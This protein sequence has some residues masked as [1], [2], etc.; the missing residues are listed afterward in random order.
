MLRPCVLLLVGLSFASSAQAQ[1]GLSY[2]GDTNWD[3]STG[4]IPT[5]YVGPHIFS[6]VEPHHTIARQEIFGPVLAVM[7][8]KSFGMNVLQQFG[9][10]RRKIV[11][12]ATQG[13]LF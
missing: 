6:H 4:T 12:A 1:T 11:Q 3:A 7:H 9:P 10:L 2:T 8:A 13:V 5:E